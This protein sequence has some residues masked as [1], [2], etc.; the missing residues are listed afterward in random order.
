VDITAML[1]RREQVKI[2]IDKD[3]PNFLYLNPDS[4][5][6]GGNEIMNIPVMRLFQTGGVWCCPR[7]MLPLQRLRPALLSQYGKSLAVLWALMLEV[8][9]KAW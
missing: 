7:D 3:T 4:S 6:Q 9:L 2:L 8:G 5:P 1:V